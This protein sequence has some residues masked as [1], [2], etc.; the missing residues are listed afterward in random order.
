ML[1]T[2]RR[3]LRVVAAMAAI[4]VA[5]FATAT[6]V[7]ADWIDTVTASE[8]TLG[9]WEGYYYTTE[10]AVVNHLRLESA[11]VEAYLQKKAGRP[12]GELMEVA[13]LWSHN[14]ASRWNVVHEANGLLESLSTDA[15]TAKSIAAVDQFM[16][17]IDR[18]IELVEADR[19]D[20]FNAWLLQM[21]DVRAHLHDIAQRA[22]ALEVEQRQNYKQSL[23]KAGV[24][25]G[26]STSL[27]ALAILTIL[28]AASLWIRARANQLKQET[29]ANEYKRKVVEAQIEAA[30]TTEQEE[31][32]RR[33]FLSRVAHELRTPMQSLLQ[34][35]D[36]IAQYQQQVHDGSEEEL[37]TISDR[38]QFA[39]EQMSVQLRDLSDYARGQGGP[40]GRLH[41]EPFDPRSW[42]ESVQCSVEP[43]R[44]AATAAVTF[45]SEIDEDRLLLGDQARL[46]QVANNL[47][48][49]A[50]KYTSK[51]FVRVTL[52]CTPKLL[53]GRPAATLALEVADS[54]SGIAQED[55]PYVME[56]NFRGSNAR[57]TQS[58]GLGLA[59]V[60]HLMA[61][62]HGSVDLSSEL[63]V[64]TVVRASLELPVFEERRRPAALIVGNEALEDLAEGMNSVGWDV[65]VARDGAEA[66][67]LV[68]TIDIDLLV[69]DMQIGD[70]D[71]V[72][73]AKSLR[74]EYAEHGKKLHLVALTAAS[75]DKTAGLELFER[76]LTKP[77]DLPRLQSLTPAEYA[78]D[79]AGRAS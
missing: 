18:G 34:S 65:H 28:T 69:I 79:G 30:T 6:W 68:H 71:A 23:D 5:L 39:V 66:L 1:A 31:R 8:E 25:L 35:S 76:T 26:V 27:L 3:N 49:N 37:R 53:D 20:E 33:S 45:H 51:G 70:V 74:D 42:F 32:L 75:E 61:R 2:A 54:G 47:I 64:G 14:F 63:G 22:R 24:R 73:F 9:P 16:P 36:R 7:A 15:D 40:E 59:I 67:A 4:S 55:L 78:G 12:P 19:F 21:Q 44:E 50:I 62:M 13:V 72:Q 43:L 17:L 41:V 57:G 11:I 29:Q 38:I 52:R 58:M 10:Q 56:P 77:V 46:L 48:A 60:S